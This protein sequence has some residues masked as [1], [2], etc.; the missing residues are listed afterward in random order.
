MSGSQSNQS[1]LFGREASDSD[2]SGYVTGEYVDHTTLA[3]TPSEQ[4]NQEGWQVVRRRE[5]ARTRHRGPRNQRGPITARRAHRALGTIVQHVDLHYFPE[6]NAPSDQG[7]VTNLASGG[8]VL[9]KRRLFLVLGWMGGRLRECPILTYSGYELRE[10][11]R[12]TWPEYCSIRPPHVPKQG[13]TNQSR[14]NQVLDI[15][16][17]E[18]A[19][20]MSESMVVHLADVRSR[21]TDI[22]VVVKGAVSREALDYASKK[23]DDLMEEATAIVRR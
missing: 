9:E 14:G 22:G 6:G 2:D 15:E 13:F 3:R 1:A 8:Q 7:P 21:D 5:P 20:E 11:D 16:W 4:A 12:A 19:G 18:W 10:R 23:M 17:V